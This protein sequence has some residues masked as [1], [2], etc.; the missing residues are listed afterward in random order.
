MVLDIG[1]IRNVGRLVNDG[2]IIANNVLIDASPGYIALVAVDVLVC[3]HV[4]IRAVGGKFRAESRLRRQRRPSAV[5]TALAPSH[6]RGRPRR[7]WN[8]N[9]AC[10]RRVVPAA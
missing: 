5:S 10:R 7:T 6:P 8:P 9:P 4:A 3:G 2:D 1:D